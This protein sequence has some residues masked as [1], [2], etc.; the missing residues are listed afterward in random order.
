MTCERPRQDVDWSSTAAIGRRSDSPT[1]RS[2]DSRS[3]PGPGR[4]RYFLMSFVPGIQ[5][6]YSVRPP[7]YRAFDGPHRH[8]LVVM[9]S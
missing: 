1:G 3:I 4:I 7:F 2:R 5:E 8:R 9:S 6:Y